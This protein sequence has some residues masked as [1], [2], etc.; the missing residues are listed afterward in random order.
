MGIRNWELGVTDHTDYILNYSTLTVWSLEFEVCS[1]LDRSF[2]INCLWFLVS[3]FWFFNSII[4]Y[5]LLT[6]LLFDAFETTDPEV[7]E[8]RHKVAQRISEVTSTPCFSMSLYLFWFQN[9]INN[10]IVNTQ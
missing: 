1:C 6:F 9:P 4:H 5:R 7:R 10:S 2:T 8:Q 3:G